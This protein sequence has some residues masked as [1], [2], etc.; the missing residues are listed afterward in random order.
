[1]LNPGCEKPACIQT[2]Q[3]KP[4]AATAGTACV[5][6]RDICLSLP[7]KIIVLLLYEIQSLCLLLNLE[8][9]QGFPHFQQ[10]NIKKPWLGTAL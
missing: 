10:S 5:Q 9:V 3:T 2:A 4:S 8:M 6:A 1:V 7:Y